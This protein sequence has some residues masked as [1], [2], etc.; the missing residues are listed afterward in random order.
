MAGAVTAPAE[1]LERPDE[2][3]RGGRKVR[4]ARIN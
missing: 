3:P 2:D 1:A 4:A